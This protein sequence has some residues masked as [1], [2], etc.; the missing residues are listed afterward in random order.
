MERLKKMD[1][2]ILEFSCGNAEIDRVLKEKAVND[3][4]YVTYLFRDSETEEVIAFASINCSGIIF[5]EGIHVE[6]LP[7]VEIRYFAVAEKYQH[8]QMQEYQE[9]GDNK[10]CISDFLFCKLIEEIRE[11]TCSTIGA[12][13]IALYSVP[14]AV[15]FYKRNC[16][17]EFKEIFTPENKMYTHDCV[18][19]YHQI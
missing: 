16:F 9:Y 18:P 14:N 15:G 17:E 11:I 7:A 1:A 2:F 10:F 5:Q 6:V 3:T 4:D 13:Y 12:R 19:M 8:I